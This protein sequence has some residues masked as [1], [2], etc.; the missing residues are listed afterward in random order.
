MVVRI[1]D[2]KQ[3]YSKVTKLLVKPNNLKINDK[4]SALNIYICYNIDEEKT[5]E[6]C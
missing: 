4:Y 3:N 5:Y 2:K 1:S 6:S